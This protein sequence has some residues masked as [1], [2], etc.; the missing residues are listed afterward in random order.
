[1]LGIINKIKDIRL[2]KTWRK[3]N[4]HNDIHLKVGASSY[5]QIHAGR[6]SY[7]RISVVI[8]NSVDHLFI[9]NFLSIASGVRFIIGG[10][11]NMANFTTFPVDV[12][13]KGV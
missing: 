3:L 2:R 7:G 13:I 8:F 12:L 10:I 6:F 4:A 1:M 5:R 9:D 11:H